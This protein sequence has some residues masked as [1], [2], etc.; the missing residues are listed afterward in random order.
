MKNSSKEPSKKYS[1]EEKRQ[2]AQKKSAERLKKNGGENAVELF[3]DR[4]NREFLI[5]HGGSFEPYPEAKIKLLLVRHG[6]D[7][8]ATHST[9]VPAIDWPFLDAMDNRKVDYAGSIPGWRK[10]FHTDPAGRKILITEEA[11]GVFEPIEKLKVDPGDLF[12]PNFIFELLGPEQA[13]HY[14]Y[15]MNVA[16]RSLRRGDFRPAPFTWIVGKA[17]CGKS[18]LQFIS[19]MLLG[20]RSQNPSNQLFKKAN[21][22]GQLAKGEYWMFGDPDTTTD[23]RTRLATGENLKT[24][25]HEEEFTFHAKNREEFTASCFRRGSGSINDQQ[26][27]IQIIPPMISGV[28]DK[29]TLYRCNMAV[30]S[31]ARFIQDDQKT[32]EGFDADV[33]GADRIAIKNAVLKEV[34]QVRAWL[35]SHYNNIPKKWRDSRYGVAAYHHKELFM[36]LAQLSPEARFLEY[37]DEVLFG[38]GAGHADS[39]Y[40]RKRAKEIESVMR[41]SKFLHQVKDMLHKTGPYFG[42]LAQSHP[43]RISKDGFDANGTQLWKITNPFAKPMEEKS[44][45]VIQ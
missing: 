8:Y 42:R 10:G 16:L 12:I 25:F 34:P 3:Y 24:M 2:F 19:K 13:D 33:S 44:D 4:H 40:I 17:N 27:H 9:G 32:L 7:P 5:M 11:Q 38:E 30:Y 22:N 28:S 23:M 41:E 18:L 31:L 21:F 36:E 20:G 45:A 43:N 29:N 1:R 39:Q 6:I 14:C 37:V 26:E 35:L 15:T